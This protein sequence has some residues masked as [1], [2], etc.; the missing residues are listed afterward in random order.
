MENAPVY[1]SNSYTS[2]IYL[3]VVWETLLSRWMQFNLEAESLP[4]VHTQLEFSDYSE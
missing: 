4:A 2:F 1:T 3:T